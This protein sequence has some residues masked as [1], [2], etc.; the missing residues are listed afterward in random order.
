MLVDDMVTQGAQTPKTLGLMSIRY[1]SNV[2]V[3]D[4]YLID[5]DSRDF[6]ISLLMWFDLV[7]APDEQIF[8]LTQITWINKKQIIKHHFS[9]QPRDIHVNSARWT[10]ELVR[11][12]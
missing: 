6:T 11:A 7:L 10:I 5:I 1:R 9:Q 3:L 8:L 2:K 12:I 4:L